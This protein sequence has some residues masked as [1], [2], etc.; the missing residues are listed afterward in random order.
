MEVPRPL[1]YKGEDI[2]YSLWKHKVSRYQQNAIDRIKGVIARPVPNEWLRYTA[3]NINEDDPE[4]VVADKQVNINIAA[5]IKPWFF[6]YRYPSLKRDCKRY[7]TRGKAHYA[8]QFNGEVETNATDDDDAFTCAKWYNRKMPVSVAPSTMNRICWAIEN[9]FADMKVFKAKDFDYQILKS[10][11]GSYTETQKKQIAKLYDEY[12]NTV[13]QTL[14]DTIFQT[15]RRDLVI[16]NLEI[17]K[18]G[19]LLACYKVCPY[20]EIL[21]DVMLDV[22]YSTNRSKS[23]AWELCGETIFR[24][25]L[26]R[27][28]YDIMYPVQD[29]DGEL[30]FCGEKFSMVIQHIE[31]ESL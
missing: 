29:P 12:L 11:A 30:E 5:E 6:I 21:T 3:R 28:D 4:D 1:N 24:N 18:Y 25:V 17:I 14:I 22:M 19:F 2:V 31:G 16:D 27:N 23:F 20:D 8:T 9:E 13:K 10:T 7:M 15:G 26:K